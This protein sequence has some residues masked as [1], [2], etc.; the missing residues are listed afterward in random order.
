MGEYDGS[1][2]SGECMVAYPANGW[3][4]VIGSASYPKCKCGSWRQHWLTFSG[5]KSPGEYAA[6]YRINEPENGAHIRNAAVRGENIASLCHECNE[7]TDEFS[8]KAGTLLVP[9][10]R[11]GT[12]GY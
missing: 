2:C 4:N 5:A 1:R 10:S 11:K 6:E 7:Q 8:Q 12:C 9:A 3:R